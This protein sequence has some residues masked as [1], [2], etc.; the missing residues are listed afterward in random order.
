MK[1]SSD[2]ATSA[3][4]AARRE[5][6][7]EAH[8]AVVDALARLRPLVVQE[9][10]PDIDIGL[11][12]VLRGSE[13][14]W[15]AWWLYA[16]LPATPE[17]CAIVPDLRPLVDVAS[18]AVADDWADVRTFLAGHDTAIRLILPEESHRSP[19]TRAAAEELISAGIDVR[20]GDAAEWF[21]VSRDRV[22][23]APMRWGVADDVDIAVLRGEP[24]VS[25]LSELFE[26]RWRVARP[27]EMTDDHDAVLRLLAE[28][29]G[30]EEVAQQL[31]TSVRTVR[32]R[33]AE[34][35][36]AY[37]ASSRFQLGLRLGQGP[38]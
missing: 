37:G 9:G 20:T 18:G 24:I 13:G 16:D 10:Q 25:A 22:A 35:M 12:D 36:D 7:E 38:A 2:R 3:E 6:W 15:Q 4:S 31:G 14:V 21:F 33:V 32:R 23:V 34:A 26:H 11:V 30:D 19:V 29:L 8:A 17:V 5:A 1:R 28:G 27:W